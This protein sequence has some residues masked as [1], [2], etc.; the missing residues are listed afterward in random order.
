MVPAERTKYTTNRHVPSR[1]M[2]S[3]RSIMPEAD[4]PMA[5]AAGYHAKLEEEQKQNFIL[6]GVLFA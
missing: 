6:Q 5:E 3:P 2:K 4:Q 1:R